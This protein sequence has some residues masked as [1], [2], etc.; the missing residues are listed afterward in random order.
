M[1]MDIKKDII[2]WIQEIS[3]LYKG[4]L[5]AL[6][7]HTLPHHLRKYKVR[8]LWEEFGS[9]QEAMAQAGLLKSIKLR[10]T[11]EEVI[12]WLVEIKLDPVTVKGLQTV[13]NHYSI[14]TINR[15]FG[16]L[17][18]ICEELGLPFNTTCRINMETPIDSGTTNIY[19]LI[20]NPPNLKNTNIDKRADICIYLCSIYDI[21]HLKNNTQPPFNDKYSDKYIRK[22]FDNLDNAYKEAGICPIKY[23]IIK[24]MYKIYRETG[25]ITTTSHGLNYKK[26]VKYFGNF[27]NALIEAKIIENYLNKCEVCDK[28]FEGKVKKDICKNCKTVMKYSDQVNKFHEDSIKYKSKAQVNFVKKMKKLLPNIIT[29]NRFFNYKGA[30]WDS[31]IIDEVNKIAIYWYNSDAKYTQANKFRRWLISK[32]YRY[33]YFTIEEDKNALVSSTMSN[34]G[35]GLIVNPNVLASEIIKYLDKIGLIKYDNS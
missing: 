20:T 14:I 24:N 29:W 26:I 18:I 21:D 19:D 8:D 34:K 25:T 28:E 2:K 31:T 30:L 1:D 33:K 12:D 11:A 16:G 6:T 27:K 5:T 32:K 35:N 7:L 3:I 4:S 22:Y 13:E 23:E 17:A 9:Y 10:A 15:L